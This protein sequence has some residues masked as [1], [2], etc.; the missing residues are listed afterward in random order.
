[1]ESSFLRN[2]LRRSKCY[3]IQ[4][5]FNYY[6]NVTVDFSKN[7]NLK[8]GEA[9]LSMIFAIDFC[10]RFELIIWRIIKKRFNLCTGREN[11]S[12][13]TTN[14]Q[15][16]LMLVAQ[17]IV[18]CIYTLFILYLCDCC[19]FI[20]FSMFIRNRYLYTIKLNWTH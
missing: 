19:R 9:L 4:I 11:K 20:C 2:L 16:N 18:S 12:T 5:Q 8:I 7:R 3:K 14:S 6:E 17:Y 13:A 10:L 1:M 15:S